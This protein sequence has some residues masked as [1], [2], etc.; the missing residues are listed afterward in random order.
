MS[1]SRGVLVIA[2]TAAGAVT[3]LTFEAIGLARRI[4]KT[5]RSEVAACVL[6]ADGSAAAQQLLRQGADAVYQVDATDL[7]DYQAEAWLPDVLAV[8]ARARP[9]TVIAGHSTIGADLAPRIAFRLGSAVVT[10]CIEVEIRGDELHFTRQ[11]YGGKAN[12]VVS[13]STSPAVIT[14]K[15]KSFEA[16]TERTDGIGRIVAMKSTL[17]A[18]TIR[19]RLRA[20]QGT[21]NEGVTLESARRIVAGGGGMKGPQG[22]EMASQLASLLGAAVGASRVACDLGWCPP[23]YQIGLSG[24]TVA[25]ELYLAIGI[26]GTGQ[27]MAGCANAKAIVAINTDRNAPIFRFAKY[28]IVQDCHELMPALIEQ[29]ERRQK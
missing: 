6:S 23:S 22:F 26:S 28:G 5:L 15:A 9:G 2:E 11:C 19:T 25:P 21:N 16:S 18:Q 17:D 20:R 29:L 24:K 12:E 10:A 27:H 1:D 14:I 3:P 8:N 7:A 4:A 13:V